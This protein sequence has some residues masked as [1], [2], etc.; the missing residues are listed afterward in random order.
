MTRCRLHVILPDDDEVPEGTNWNESTLEEL[1][2]G[3]EDSFGLVETAS[4]QENKREWVSEVFEETDRNVALV[5]EFERT[6]D[7]LLPNAS[8]ILTR[9]ERDLM[10]GQGATFDYDEA[11]LL[12]LTFR[13]TT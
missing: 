8:S 5:D 3:F 13:L 10:D 4:V 12:Q 7:E 6:C 9:Q 1:R 11:L 2:S